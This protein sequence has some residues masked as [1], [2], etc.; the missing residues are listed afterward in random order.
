MNL[1]YIN[2]F[3][4]YFF[5]IFA[6][7]KKKYLLHSQPVVIIIYEL[8]LFLICFHRPIFSLYCRQWNR[9]HSLCCRRLLFYNYYYLVTFFIYKIVSLR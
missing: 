5:F 6:Y 7:L 4:E 2:M 8:I 1:I 9:G 3:V